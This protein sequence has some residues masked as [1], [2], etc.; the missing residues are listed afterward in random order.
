MKIQLERTAEVILRRNLI[1]SVQI[2]E[3]KMKIY[4]LNKLRKGN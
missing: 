3:K 4:C 1:T 2:L